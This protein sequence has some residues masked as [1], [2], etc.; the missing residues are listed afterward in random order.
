M[1]GDAYASVNLVLSKPFAPASR[2]GVFHQSTLVAGYG[3]D[4]EEDDLAMQSLLT[5]APGGRFRLTAGAFYG[6]VPGVSPTVGMQ[7]LRAGERWFVLVSPRVNVERDPSSSIFSILRYGR[8]AGPGRRLYLS[9]QALNTFDAY[10]HIKSY[11]WMRVGLD[12]RGTQF[13][14]GVNFDEDGPKPRVETSIGVFV[15]RE[16]F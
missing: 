9:M 16:V 10:R 14:L 3:E 11:Q 12:L 2:W 15:R 4:D 8:G 5:F 1:A 7:Y 6:S 13:G